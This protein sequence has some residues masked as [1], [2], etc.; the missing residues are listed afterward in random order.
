MQSVTNPGPSKSYDSPSSPDSLNGDED[1]LV[2]R[3]IKILA[4]NFKQFSVRCSRF[5]PYHLA[6]PE[7]AQALH[8]ELGRLQFSFDHDSYV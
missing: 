1:V 4:D 3:Q 6:A 2:I 8:A 5:D 7:I